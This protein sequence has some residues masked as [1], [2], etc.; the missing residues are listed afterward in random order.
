MQCAKYVCVFMGVLFVVIFISGC[1]AAREPVMIDPMLLEHQPVTISI[2][3]SIDARR[4]KE[5]AKM[6]DLDNIVRPC[7]KKSLKKFRK[8]K[9]IYL[10]NY[11]VNHPEGYLAEM[12]DDELI[13]LAPENVEA[14]YLYIMDDLTSNNKI[15]S[16]SAQVKCR[17]YLIDPV[18]KK[19]IW[20]DEHSYSRGGAG[21]AYSFMSLKN[22]VIRD[23]IITMMQSLPKKGS[24]PK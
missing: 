10:D 4:D 16:N 19:I 1:A 20:K 6:T 9:V 3:P 14:A 21:L 24:K 18:N 17:A 22:D 23:S 13:T 15:I 12:S 11:A 5:G 8:Y 7:V 2:L